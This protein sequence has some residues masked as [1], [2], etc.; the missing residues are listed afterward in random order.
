MSAGHRIRIPRGYKL[1]RT[2]GKL[3]PSLKHLDVS[4][5]LKRQASKAIKPIRRTTP[6]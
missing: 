2:T 5:R 3:V 4:T 1:D 6:R